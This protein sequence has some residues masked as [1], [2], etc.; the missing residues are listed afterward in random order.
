MGDLFALLLRYHFR[1]KT[2]LVATRNQIVTTALRRTYQ[3]RIS[4]SDLKIFCVSNTDYWK[5]RSRPKDVAL[6]FL[7]L[8]RILDVRRHCISIV[9]QSQ[10]RAAKNYIRDDVPALLGSI[11]LWTQSGAGG[12]GVEQR[13]AIHNGVNE[14]ERQFQEVSLRQGRIGVLR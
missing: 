10:L 14:I 5:Y 12:V 6:P 4:G 9:A 2:H 8:S 13:Q 1:M 11:G 3:S 7:R